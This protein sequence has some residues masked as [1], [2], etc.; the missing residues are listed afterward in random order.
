MSKKYAIPVKGTA[1]IRKSSTKKTVA[2]T[3]PIFNP[4]FRFTGLA[5]YAKK[6]IS[7]VASGVV[8]IQ[9]HGAS[10]LCPNTTMAVI[11]TEMT[12]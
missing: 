9:T 2:Q 12:A 6:P 1:T 4:A 8:N 10:E 11:S 7:N 5:T 3:Q